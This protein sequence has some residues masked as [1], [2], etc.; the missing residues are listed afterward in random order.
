VSGFDED[1]PRP[2]TPEERRAIRTLRRLA[3]TWPDTLWLY[4]ASGSLQVMQTG[5]DGEHVKT[6]RLG[7]DQDFVITTIGIPNDGGDW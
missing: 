6:S 7:V 1:G 2:L 4:S 3:K 5:P